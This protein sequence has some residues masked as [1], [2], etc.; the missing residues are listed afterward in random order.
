MGGHGEKLPI[1]TFL[2]TVF[3]KNQEISIQHFKTG[4]T[5]IGA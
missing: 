5:P 1:D 4:E 2:A 3:L